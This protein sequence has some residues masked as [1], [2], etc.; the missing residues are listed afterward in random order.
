M[1]FL[2]L[3]NQHGAVNSNSQ[4]NGSGMIKEELKDNSLDAGVNSSNDMIKKNVQKVQK[5]QN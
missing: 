4:T 5:V 1:K 2:M 3:K